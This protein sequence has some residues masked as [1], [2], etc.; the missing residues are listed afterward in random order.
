[1][2]SR[3]GT[4]EGTREGMVRGRGGRKTKTEQS[5]ESEPERNPNC[6]LH[7]ALLWTSTNEHFLPVFQANIW[8]DITENKQTNKQKY[9]GENAI[10]QMG[11][12]FY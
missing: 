5:S 10:L 6:N 1:M 8:T 9:K 12:F 4:H 11:K 3:K 7:K 2:N